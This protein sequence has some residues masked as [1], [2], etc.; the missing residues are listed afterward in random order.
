MRIKDSQDLIYMSIINQLGRTIGKSPKRLVRL[1]QE[2]AKSDAKSS[3]KLHK[4]STYN[5]VINNSIH[6]TTRQR[7]AIGKEL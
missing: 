4:S 3:S 5:E 1:V 7:K 2:F 6:R